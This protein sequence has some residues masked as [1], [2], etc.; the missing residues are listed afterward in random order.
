MLDV[1]PKENE[2]E[3]LDEPNDENEG[4]DAAGA[5]KPDVAPKAGAADA[6]LLL[7]DGTTDG[8]KGRGGLLAPKANGVLADVVVVVL[9]PAA[10]KL[11]PPTLGVVPNNDGAELVVGLLVNAVEVE[12]EPNGAEK[13]KPAVVVVAAALVIGVAEADKAKR[14]AV[15]KVDDDVVVVG[16]A[17]VADAPKGPDAKLA[18]DGADALVPKENNPG[19]SDAALVLVLVLV[20]GVALDAEGNEPNKIVGAVLG[21]ALVVLVN[22]AAVVAAGTVADVEGVVKVLLLDEKA[23]KAGNVVVLVPKRFELLLVVVVVVAVAAV[24]V[25]ADETPNN[26]DVVG[27]TNRGR[28]GALV[29]GGAGLITGFSLVVTGTDTNGV[30]E[31]GVPKGIERDA[32]VMTGGAILTGVASLVVEGNENVTVGVVVI[33]NAIETGA[34]ATVAVAVVGGVSVKV[35]AT[36]AVLVVVIVVD[37]AVASAVVSDEGLLT[38]DVVAGSGTKRWKYVDENERKR[39]SYHLIVY[40]SD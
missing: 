28:V 9:A 38:V 3:L 19:R 22:G 39:K 27:G 20:A 13:E 37:T 21:E 15:G 14:F 25:V 32:A 23:P 26:V 10:G 1:A 8:A 2:G 5:P 11:N 35:G 12:L 29:T 34:G 17:N 7:P 16:G 30:D 6:V 4:A 18:N 24:V 31:A 33:G 36:V 40:N